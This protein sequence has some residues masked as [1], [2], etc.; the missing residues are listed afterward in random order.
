MATDHNIFQHRHLR[1]KPDILKGSGQSHLRYPIRLHAFQTCPGRTL[2]IQKYITLGWAIKTGYTIKKCGFAGPVGTDQGNDLAL[3]D[4][5]I[6][7][8]EGP[9]PAKVHGE[10]DYLEN[11]PVHVRKWYPFLVGV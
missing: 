4:I 2:S 5:K 6:N 1:E 8:V 3:L 7:V 9:Y 11:S 10:T